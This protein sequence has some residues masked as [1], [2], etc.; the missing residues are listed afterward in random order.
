MPLTREEKAEIIKKFAQAK[1]DTGS[2]QVQIALLTLEITKL[3]THLEEH[4]HD[5]PAKRALLGK[6]AK[7]RRLLRYLASRNPDLYQSVIK[8]LELKKQ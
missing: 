5:F 2:P 3:R 4:K 8:T 1:G 7:R 6:V